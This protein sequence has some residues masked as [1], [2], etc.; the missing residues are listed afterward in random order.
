LELNC[1]ESWISAAK[2]KLAINKKAEVTQTIKGDFFEAGE[3][4]TP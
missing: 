4:A 1:G 3:F 2:P